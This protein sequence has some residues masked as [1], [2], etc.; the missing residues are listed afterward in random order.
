MENNKYRIEI[1]RYTPV[2]SPAMRFNYTS[3]DIPD[4]IIEKI[5]EITDSENVVADRILLDMR[6]F[7]N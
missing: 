2:M 6:V 5:L 3:I 7:K 1:R 4:N